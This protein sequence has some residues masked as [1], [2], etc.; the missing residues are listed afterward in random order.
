[1]T[2][3]SEYMVIYDLVCKY[4]HSFEGWFKSE[5]DYKEQKESQLLVCPICESSDVHKV[6]SAT[7]IISQSSKKQSNKKNSHSKELAALNALS[8]LILNNSEDVGTEF[9]HEAKKMHYGETDKRAI[10]GQA[11]VQEVK[12]LNQEG[13]EVLALP[14]KTNDKSK[15]N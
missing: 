11:T 10:R 12:E 15:L 7:H 8:E 1:M 4:E 3:L 2:V 9:A 13:I 5:H 14:Q 6:P